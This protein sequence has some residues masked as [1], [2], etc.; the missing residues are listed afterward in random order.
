MDEVKKLLSI[1]CNNLDKTNKLGLPKILQNIWIQIDE[2]DKLTE[3]ELIMDSINNSSEKWKEKGIKLNSFL[4]E[5]VHKKDLKKVDGNI[6]N[7]QFYLEQAKT[8]LEQI[9]N[10]PKSESLQ[11]YFHIQIILM[12]Q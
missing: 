11:H 2:E 10:L 12:I 9:L 6:S 7:V 5:E 1:T 4:L 8:E 3:F